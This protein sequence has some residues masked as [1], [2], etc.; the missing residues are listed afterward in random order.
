LSKTS[1]TIG[2]VIFNIQKMQFCSLKTYIR[3]LYRVGNRLGVS[4]RQW[5]RQGQAVFLRA[6][7]E[8]KWI[9]CVFSLP[10]IT[11]FDGLAAADSEPKVAT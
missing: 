10:L 2:I 3:G 11:N 9:T 6:V 4:L 8:S 7:F 5:S 1:E